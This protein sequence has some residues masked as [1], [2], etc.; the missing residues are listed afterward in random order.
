MSPQ[1]TVSADLPSPYLIQVQKEAVSREISNKRYEQPYQTAMNTSSVIHEATRW[2]WNTY[3]EVIGEIN[4]VD[5]K[6]VPFFSQALT[7][8]GNRGDLHNI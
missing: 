4:E 1:F 8:F 3:E 5:I 2:H 7:H 6:V